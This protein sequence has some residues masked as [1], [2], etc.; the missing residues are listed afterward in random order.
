MGRL[1]GEC[2]QGVTDSQG[3]GRVCDRYE[4]KRASV[5]SSTNGWKQSKADGGVA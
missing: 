4:K 3:H 1:A 2:R 5:T